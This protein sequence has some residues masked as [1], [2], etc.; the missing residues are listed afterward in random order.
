MASLAFSFFFLERAILCWYYTLGRGDVNKFPLPAGQKQECFVRVVYQ[1]S[2]KIHFTYLQQTNT[3]QL[4]SHDS[5]Y[6]GNAAGCS[7]EA[8]MQVFLL[9]VGRVK[10]FSRALQLLLLVCILRAPQGLLQCQA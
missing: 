3:I 5:D 10:R 2:R 9:L 4:P 7:L 6:M 8:R 1:K